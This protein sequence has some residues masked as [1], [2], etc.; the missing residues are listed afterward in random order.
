MGK[1]HPGNRLVRVWTPDAG[2]LNMMTR[3]EQIAFM[4]GTETRHN[5]MIERWKGHPM[6]ATT[7]RKLQHMQTIWKWA[8]SV[9]L[10]YD[11]ECVYPFGFAVNAFHVDLSAIAEDT[12]LLY[13][14]Q[15]AIEYGQRRGR[16]EIRDSLANLLTRES[17]E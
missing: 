10:E 8:E 16:N 14:I 17:E 5:A 1:D 12:F 4:E 15:K 3:E 7:E 13:T 9:G 2:R 11:G 6:F